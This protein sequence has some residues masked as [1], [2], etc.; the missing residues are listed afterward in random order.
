MP[1]HIKDKVSD[2]FGCLKGRNQKKTTAMSVTEGVKCCHSMRPLTYIIPGSPLTYRPPCSYICVCVCADRQ[3]AR[4]TVHRP[5]TPTPMQRN[6]LPPFPDCQVTASPLLAAQRQQRDVI[7]C[8]PFLTSRNLA[9]V[10]LSYKIARSSSSYVVRRTRADKHTGT[11]THYAYTM[12][13]KTNINV[14]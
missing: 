11:H 14:G 7:C 4:G 12:S 6:P 5:S 13:I 2:T 1:K 3:S 8:S 9:S 10:R